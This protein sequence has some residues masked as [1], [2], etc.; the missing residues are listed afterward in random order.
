MRLTIKTEPY[1][2]R[3]YGKPYI[4]RMDFS[5]SPQGEVSWGDWVGQPG[6]EGVLVLE[7]EPGDVIMVGQ[8]DNRNSRKSV[9]DYY[10]V[11]EGCGDEAM[12]GIEEFGIANVDRGPALAPVSKAAGYGYFVKY[13]SQEVPS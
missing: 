6:E 2:D 10:I 7:A 9:P 11:A 4:A 5:S 12:N 1:N 3:R 8:K 13:R